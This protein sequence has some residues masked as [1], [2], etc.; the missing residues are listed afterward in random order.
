MPNII[1]TMVLFILKARS[2]RLDRSKYDIN[3]GLF[4]IKGS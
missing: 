1:L 4:R 2:K 3:N